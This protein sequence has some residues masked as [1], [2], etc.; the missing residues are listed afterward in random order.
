MAQSLLHARAFLLYPVATKEIQKNFAKP[1]D[2]YPDMLY[3]QSMAT[4]T[5]PHNTEETTMDNTRIEHVEHMLYVALKNI[6]K[7]KKAFGPNHESIALHATSRAECAISEALRYI[8]SELEE[9]T[10]SRLPLR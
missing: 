6:D 5:H 3:I 9:L 10:F 2:I 1:L 8:H 4:N 7:A